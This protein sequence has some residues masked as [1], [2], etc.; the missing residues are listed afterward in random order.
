MTR[1]LR[2]LHRLW[3]RFGPARRLHIVEYEM[4]P[5]RMP[6]RDLVLTK[7]DGDPWSVGMLCP[8]QC[9]NVIE[10]LVTPG[11]RP[12]WDFEVDAAGRPSLSPS[13]WRKSGCRSHF[14]VRKGRI[15]WCE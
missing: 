4:L 15:M 14:W 5:T 1:L 7:D 3:D 6:H 11:V 2:W 9:R 12:R 8:C 13:V 10:I